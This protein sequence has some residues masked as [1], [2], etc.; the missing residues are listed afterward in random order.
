MAGA[1]LL[2]IVGRFGGILERVEGGMDSVE[3]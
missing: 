3:W 1:R 2:G